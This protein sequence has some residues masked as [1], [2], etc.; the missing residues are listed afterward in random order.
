[1][2]GEKQ[3]IQEDYEKQQQEERTLK[4]KYDEQIGKY[5]VLDAKHNELHAEYA[6][7]KKQHME[8]K[9]S[10]LLQVQQLQQDKKLHDTTD[11]KVS[12]TQHY[13]Y[14]I[15][16]FLNLFTFRLSTRHCSGNRNTRR[17]A[18]RLL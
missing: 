8:D 11:W 17:R 2:H 4:K 12:G 3:H 16:Y 9:N 14:S 13:T 10:L 18:W 7:S 5:K 15:T 1:M 6:K